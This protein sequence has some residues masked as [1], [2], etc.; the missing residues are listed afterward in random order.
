MDKNA[1]NVKAAT[2]A[3]KSAP[4]KRKKKVS[5]SWWMIGLIVGI[6]TLLS[7]VLIV[8]HF[9]MPQNVSVKVDVAPIVAPVEKSI[10]EPVIE[11]DR[12]VEISPQPQKQDLG[13]TWGEP[14]KNWE[15]TGEAP[16]RYG[17]SPVYKIPSEPTH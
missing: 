2:A 6:P 7:I 17:S 14:G 4:R 15:I 13:Y 16:S 9:M 5:L 12:N 8:A 1:N 3:K 11:K 10:V